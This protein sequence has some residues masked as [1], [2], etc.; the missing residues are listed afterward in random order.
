MAF[1][2]RLQYQTLNLIEIS[3]Q[4]L[5]DNFSFYQ[6][7]NPQ[8]KIC[9]VLK[10]NAYGHGLKLIGKLVDRKIKPEF[11]CVDSLYEA[12]ELRKARVMSP[13]LIMGY[14]FPENFKHKRLDFRFPLF[15]RQTL[16]VL[17]QYQPG[18]KVHLKIDTGMNRLGLKEKDVDCFISLLFRCSKVKVEGIYSHLADADSKD[19]SFSLKQIETFK[20]I[21]KKFESAGFSFKYKHLNA[22]AGALK[23]KDPEFNLIR[24][25]LGFY[26][27]PKPALR[28]ITHIVEVK[29]LDKGESVSYNRTFTAKRKT[30]IAVLPLGYYDGVDRRLSNKG[31]VKIGNLYCP[32]IG[33]VCM[34][35]TVIDVSKVKNPR[36][37]Q[38]VVVFDNSSKSKNS[39]QKTADLMGTIPYEVLVKLSETTRRVL[40]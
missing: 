13:I 39:L 12:Y 34:N 9:P 2:Q 5:K 26:L 22:T 18:A 7:K 6:Q 25:G 30:K 4:A 24:L 17:D 32:I 16:Q 8:A 28:L 20:R 1:G 29:E 37:G 3:Q 21:I 15:D 10:S 40:L 11:V 33:R 19:Q 27:E 14:T 31:V 38:E 36:V 35:L 23:F